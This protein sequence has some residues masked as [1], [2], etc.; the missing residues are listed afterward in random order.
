MFYQLDM[1]H[2]IA[3]TLFAFLVGETAFLLARLGFHSHGLQ[4]VSAFATVDLRIIVA[5]LAQVVVRTSIA[6][7]SLSAEDFSA[8]NNALL[9]ELGGVTIVQMPQ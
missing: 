6:V 8:T 9:D 2:Q 3:L 1:E 7:I 5:L 4:C